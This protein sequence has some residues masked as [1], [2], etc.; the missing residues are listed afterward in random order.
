MVPPRSPHEAAHLDEYMNIRQVEPSQE[1]EEGLPTGDRLFH[2][3]ANSSDGET[4]YF[5]AVHQIGEGGFRTAC[6]CMRAV[7]N[8]ARSQNAPCCKHAAEALKIVNWKLR[9][10]N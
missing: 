3:F 5:V 10:N 2:F 9:A 1:T 4:E 8:F 7:F 6:Q